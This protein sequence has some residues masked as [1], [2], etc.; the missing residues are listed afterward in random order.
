MYY[1]KV[2]ALLECFNIYPNH[3]HH[4][5]YYT[6]VTYYLIQAVDISEIELTFYSQAFAD[7]DN[8]GVVFKTDGDRDS[9]SLFEGHST[10]QLLSMIKARPS[11]HSYFSSNKN[12]LK[13]IT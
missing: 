4:L 6:P 5:Y 2:T 12:K 7:G 3:L 10:A 9:I 11:S 1:K 13:H 8:E